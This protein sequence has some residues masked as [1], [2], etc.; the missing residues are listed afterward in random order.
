MNAVIH[1]CT[2][3][4]R[5]PDRAKLGDK[6]FQDAVKDDQKH[7]ALIKHQLNKKPLQKGEEVN[8]IRPPDARNVYKGDY[9]KFQDAVKDDQKHRALIKH[10]LNKKPL[11]E[12]E[13]V[14]LIRPSD[15][16]N[17]YK[18]DYKKFQDAVKDDQKHRALI[19]HQMNKK[20]LQKDA[21]NVCKG[22]Y[23]KFQDAV[24]DD[25]KHR[26]LIKHQLNK[27]PLQEGEEVKLIRPPV[28]LSGPHLPKLRDFKPLMR[29]G[30]GTFGEVYLAQKNGGVDSGAL[31]AM[32]MINISRSM[33]ERNG[34][35]KF[36][37]EYAVHERVTNVPFLVG[38]HYTFQRESNLWLA[39]DYYPGG[40]L[41][42]LLNWKRKLTESTTRLYLAEIVLAVDHLHKIGVIHRDL[43][44]ENILIDSE[45]HI[46]VTDYGL[47]KEFPPDA[48]IK[49]AYSVCGT[50]DYMAPEMI[51][52]KGYSMEVDWWSV[53]II[54]YEMMAGFRPFVIARDE[55][56]TKLRQ[57]IV[58]QTP[59]I[60]KNFT[61]IGSRFV[62]GLLE[63]MPLKRLTSGKTIKQDIMQHQFFNGINWDKVA[64]KK[65]KMPY[66][67]PYNSSK[68][69]HPVQNLKIELLAHTT[70]CKRAEACLYVAPS[71]IPSNE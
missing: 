38:L 16:R 24:K 7:R 1:P 39:V 55:S 2:P 64:S 52:G 49:R 23:K 22:D 60:P 15:A 70:G 14:K 12:G 47:C 41:R 37:T 42:D 63:K 67:P 26:A 46:A 29:L 21:R 40:D 13:E 44:P 43:K 6:K 62:R 36:R 32:K 68:D 69:V 56:K 30:K 10:Q 33:G 28:R 5:I 3:S 59:A 20:P 51:Q 45:G 71:L 54:A 58:Q 19:K 34:P 35:Q 8:L 18:G 53:G 17:V 50:S 31:Y 65:L 11:Q 9:K 61:S 27:K 25:Q 57:K 66:V 48:K 4:R